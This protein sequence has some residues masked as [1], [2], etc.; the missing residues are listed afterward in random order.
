M[1]IN[2]SAEDG[3]VWRTIGK[4]SRKGSTWFGR[5]GDII[6]HPPAW[7]GLAALMS[8]TGPRGRRAALRGGVCYLCAALAH[9]P[10]KAI[11]GRRHPPG[12]ALMQP[13]PFTSSSPRG[14]RQPTWPSCWGPLRRC[15]YCSFPCRAP[16]WRCTGHWFASELTTPLTSSPAVCSA[17]SSPCRPGSCGRPS[18]GWRR[19]PVSRSQ[20]NR[21]PASGGRL[22]KATP[23]RYCRVTTSWA[24]CS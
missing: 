9:L 14:T 21:P 2:R 12:S 3:L 22:A 4:G 24:S 20:Q 1:A 6:Q 17:S 5:A 8:A 10:I 16:R 18:V 13:G 15:R 7:A 23:R 19:M 11:V